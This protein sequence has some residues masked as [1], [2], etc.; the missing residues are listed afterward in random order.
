MVLVSQGRSSL[1]VSRTMGFASYG[2]YSKQLLFFQI[3]IQRVYQR[4]LL[5]VV[6]AY[7]L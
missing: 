7:A 2:K 6:E 1:L 5:A 3:K 4:R